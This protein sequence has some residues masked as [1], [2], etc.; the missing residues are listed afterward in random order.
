MHANTQQT[1]TQPGLR[2]AFYGDDFTGS[3]DALEVL[4][5]AG[6]KCAMFLTP[7]SAG[8]LSTLGTFDAIGIAGDS[9]AMS[10]DE[11][12]NTL[13]EVFSALK[14]LAPQVVHYKV[15]STFDSSPETGNIGHV[16]G[17][18]SAIFG[19]SA[20]PVVAGNPALGRYCIFG[21]LFALSKT[22]HAVHRIDRHPVMKSHPITPMHEADLALHIGKQKSLK[23]GRVTINQLDDDT[24]LKPAL[25][26]MAE[27]DDA[28]LFD[29]AT[30]AH[31]TAVGNILT[32]FAEQS[33]PLFVVG[34][35]G[36]E[37]G[38]IQHWQQSGQIDHSPAPDTSLT[39][40]EQLLVI[41]G[42]ASPFSYLQIK[43]A[44]EHGFVEI[45]VEA[46]A[47]ISENEKQQAAQDIIDKA[48]EL[49]QGG[50]NVVIHTAKG[51][52]DARIADMITFM[53][54]QG[55]SPEAAKTQGGK[56][57]SIELG[58]ITQ[59]ILERHPLKRIVVSGGDT[60]SQ[61]TKILAP[62]ALVIQSAIS[63]G[64]PL[65]KA[66]SE[67]PFLSGLEI[68]LK[69]GQMGDE[70]YFVQALKGKQR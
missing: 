18:A 35:S 48:I 21:N 26:K 44:I 9:R 41:S 31:L 25:E 39:P 49:L 32:T 55:A 38:L 33:S 15:C 66:L 28:I 51:S 20:V 67:K 37:Y 46:R 63:P 14:A 2:L 29:G 40:V 61:V 22:D 43:K 70:T 42:S 16:I 52:D 27:N 30:P 17:M 65:C 56:A 59:K 13:P 64:A 34:S 8:L 1:T 24:G 10:P 19:K 5:A 54:S 4:A 12:D 45:G 62:D 57:L 11:M 3:S 53:V 60:S 69:G 47:L 7:P 6:L 58:L 23:F 68:A 50:E 36:V